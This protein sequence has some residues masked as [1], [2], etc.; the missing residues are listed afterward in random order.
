L[1]DIK[2][3]FREAYKKKVFLHPNNSVRHGEASIKF[4]TLNQVPRHWYPLMKYKNMDN[5]IR[6]VTLIKL[7]P[8]N[9]NREDD[10]C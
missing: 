8:N 2:Y 7:K 6:K 1:K 9:L 10:F 3:R 4:C 5:I